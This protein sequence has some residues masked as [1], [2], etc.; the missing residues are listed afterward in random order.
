MRVPSK[1]IKPVNS[2]GNQPSILTERTEAK[3]EAIILWS[4]DV[5]S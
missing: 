2:K 5:N 1:K 3:A 4:P